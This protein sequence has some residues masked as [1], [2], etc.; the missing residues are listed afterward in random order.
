MIALLGLYVTVTIVVASVYAFLWA[1]EKADSADRSYI[2]GYEEDV[3][4]YARGFLTAPLWPL[5]LVRAFLALI[6]DAM[7]SLKGN[8]DESE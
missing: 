7:T 1:M 4:A 2:I 8:T 3:L 5:F 6:A